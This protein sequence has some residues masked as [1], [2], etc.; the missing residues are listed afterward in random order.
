MQDWREEL[1]SLFKRR[2][3]SDEEISFPEFIRKYASQEFLRRSEK[4][5]KR[6][7]ALHARG[8]WE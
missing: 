3:E 4:E 1:S 2:M 5:Q 6:R 7:E 8:I